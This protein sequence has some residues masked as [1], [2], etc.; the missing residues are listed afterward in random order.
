[1]VSVEKELLNMNRKP[2]VI[3]GGGSNEIGSLGYVACAEEILSQSFQLRISFDYVVVSS[4][5]GGTHAGL[6]VGFH[7]NNAE[8]PVIG[9][10]CG[11]EKGVQEGHVFELVEKL[12]LKVGVKQCIPR[13][14]IIC[15][16]EY[17]GPGYSLPT[18]EMVEAVKLL[19]STEGILLDPVYTGKAM[20]G[21]IALSRKGYF[22]SNDNV[23][24]IHTGGTPA[25]YTYT[26]IF[27]EN[28]VQWNEREK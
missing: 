20:A 4:G 1:M 25:L 27:F 15:F 22:R 21:L 23:L 11:K 17:V 28:T 12:R 9:I 13:D 16:D 24:F 19:A 26:D 7:G 10:N 2:Y 6:V 3:P 8:I 18:G 5:S 14:K